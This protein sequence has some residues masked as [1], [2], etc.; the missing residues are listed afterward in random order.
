MEYEVPSTRK[1]ASF[2][3]RVVTVREDPALAS[4]AMPNGRSTP[5]SEHLI[6]SP[7]YLLYFLRSCSHS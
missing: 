5:A 6:H 1:V 3:M 7:S 4:F 2:M